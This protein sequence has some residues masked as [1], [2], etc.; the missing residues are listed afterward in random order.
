MQPVKFYFN[1]SEY[2]KYPKLGTRCTPQ[3]AVKVIKD[4]DGPEVEWF[5]KHPQFKH[6]FH[7]HLH[8]MR[9]V[10]GMWML[11][12]RTACTDRD[13]EFWF[14]VNGVPIR[15]SLR[16]HGLLCGLSCHRY[17]PRYNEKGDKLG[18]LR[19]VTKHFGDGAKPTIKSFCQ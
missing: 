3:K 10:M 11:L 13:N 17:P 1:P 7:M 14:V 16:E 9:K 6:F 12:V 15:Y 5:E 8:E 19:F 18:S 4:L 2:V